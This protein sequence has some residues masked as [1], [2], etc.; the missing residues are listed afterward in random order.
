[1]KDQPANL[2]LFERHTYIRELK[3]QPESSKAGRAANKP[4]KPQSLGQSN[5]KISDRS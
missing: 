2:N 5:S 4:Q 3:S 1:M